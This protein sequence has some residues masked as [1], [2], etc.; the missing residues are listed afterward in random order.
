MEV[1]GGDM[2]LI[3][4]TCYEVEGLSSAVLLEPGMGVA[5]FWATGPQAS[6]QLGGW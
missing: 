1:E 4:M 2:I 3:L 6:I 5:R